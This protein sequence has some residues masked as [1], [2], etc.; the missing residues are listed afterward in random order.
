MMFNEFASNIELADSE[1][2]LV[3]EMQGEVGSSIL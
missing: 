1:P 3:G 2:C